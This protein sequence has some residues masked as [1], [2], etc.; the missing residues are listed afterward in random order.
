MT[1]E[2]SYAG[3]NY[4]RHHIRQIPMPH[5]GCGEVRQGGDRGITVCV[6]QELTRQLHPYK[7]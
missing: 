2:S 3:T 7:T 4:A 1:F 5:T 6:W